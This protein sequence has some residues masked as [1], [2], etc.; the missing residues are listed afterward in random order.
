MITERTIIVLFIELS[1]LSY[2]ITRRNI[3]FY[4]FT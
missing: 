2:K 3:S 4:N 1:G